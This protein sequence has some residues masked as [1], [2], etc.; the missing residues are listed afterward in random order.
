MKKCR[1][2]SLDGGGL[3]GLITARLL[4]KISHEIG[5]DWLNKV[6]VIAGTSTGGILALGLA[7]GKSPAEI[8]E[9]YV[10]HGADIFKDSIL[11]NIRDLGKLIG[12]DYSNKY[13]DKQLKN[14]FGELRLNDLDKRVV[15]P[16]FDLDSGSSKEKMNALKNQGKERKWKPKIFHNFSGNDSDGQMPIAKVA[17]YTSAAPTYFPVVDSYIDG[18]VYANNPSMIALA[19]AISQHNTY[20][21]ELSE[22]S[23]LSLGTGSHSVYIRKKNLDWGN[24]HWMP[25]IFDI[26]SD[27]TVDIAHYQLEQLLGSRYHRLQPVLKN[28]IQMDDANKMPEMEKVAENQDIDNVINWLRDNW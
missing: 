21:V 17:L 4:Q 14:I 9:L 12:A 1:V 25:Y 24:A 16:T 26:I 6:D 27:G 20:K 3:R 19:Q 13:L 28:K 2:L 23:L 5:D 18:G 22:I 7:A 11:D 8:A 10:E 15:I